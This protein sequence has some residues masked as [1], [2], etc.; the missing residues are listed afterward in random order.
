MDCRVKFLTCIWHFFQR[1]ECRAECPD[2]LC[3]DPPQGCLCR[4]EYVSPCGLNCAKNRCN[5]G[6]TKHDNLI[7]QGDLTMQW[8]RLEHL[9]THIQ[10]THI[11]LGI[12]VYFVVTTYAGNLELWLLHNK[13]FFITKY[14]SV[15]IISQPRCPS[16]ALS[17]WPIPLPVLCKCNTPQWDWSTRSF[18]SAFPSGGYWCR[19]L[20]FLLDCKCCTDELYV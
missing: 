1:N 7:T 16:P 19:Q 12:Q 17:K 11:L 4:T 10:Y 3:G 18:C 9:I 13:L 2:P 20:Q 5:T 14:F 6:C 8:W 15:P